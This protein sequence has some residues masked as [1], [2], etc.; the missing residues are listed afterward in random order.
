MKTHHKQQLPTPAIFASF[1]LLSNEIF[2]N[3]SFLAIEET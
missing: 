3:E 2:W 1:L